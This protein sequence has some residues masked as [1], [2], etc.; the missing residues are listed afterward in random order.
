M[1]SEDD[2][3]KYGS[4]KEQSKEFYDDRFSRASHWKEHYSSSRYFTM[5]KGVAD[6]LLANDTFKILEIGC[7][8]GQ[9]A[10]LL[11]DSGIINYVGVDF[12]SEAIQLARLLCPNYTF[13]E[14]N[15]TDSSLL[16][17]SD[18]NCLIATEFL[19]HIEKDLEVIEKIKSNTIIIASVPNFTSVAH[20]R[21]FTSIDSVLER[22]SIFIKEIMIKEYHLKSDKKIFL[23]HGVRK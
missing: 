13:M 23:F 21:F 12:S 17:E 22:Y 2:L 15:V 1:F 10:N 11:Y 16:F 4:G 7:G 6:I 19:E 9:L 20:V 18:Y 14:S 3:R 5:W 8:P